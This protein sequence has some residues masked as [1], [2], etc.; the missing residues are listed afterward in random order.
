MARTN[1]RIKK[2]QTKI[3]TLQ[4][5]WDV[6]A[7]ELVKLDTEHCAFVGTVDDFPVRKVALTTY[8]NGKAQNIFVSTKMVRDIEKEVKGCTT[9]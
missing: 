6:I 5:A 4:E 9:L 8:K 3:I 7:E 1:R 2:K